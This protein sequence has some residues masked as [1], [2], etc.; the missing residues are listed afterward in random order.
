M[1]VTHQ[2]VINLLLDLKDK[3]S[4]TPTDV[5]LAIT[6]ISFDISVLELFLPLISG[7]RVHLATREQSL[8][9]SWLEKTIVETPITFMQATPA[10]WELLLAAGWR[11]NSALTILCGGEALRLELSRTFIK[12]KC[13]CFGIYTDQQKQRFGRRLKKLLRKISRMRGTEL[14]VSESRLPIHKFMLLIMSVTHHR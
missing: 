14:S 11:G 5:L 9:A 8:D 4:I 10:T 3:I 6:T 7:A 2:S 1:L 12:T 13:C